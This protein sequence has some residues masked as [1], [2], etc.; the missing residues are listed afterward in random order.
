MK[1]YYEDNHCIIYHGDS[2]EILTNLAP[3]DVVL[4]D[5]P[6]GMEY[7]SNYRIGGNPF[8]KIEGDSLYD[9]GMISNFL[10]I[11][12]CG[13]FA[14]GRWDNLTGM[15]KPKSVIVWVK[16]NWGMGDLEHEFARQWE[17]CAFWAGED[18]K[19]ANGRPQDVIHHDRVNPSSMQHPTQKPVGLM[20]KLLQSMECETVLDP[21]MGS[22]STLRAAK[23]LGKKAI[24]I[25]L[26][27]RYCEVAAKRLRQE[28]FAFD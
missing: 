24:G 14:F 3:V 2:R 27:E 4:T 26:E 8:G 10:K 11:A 7:K 23:D 22:G 15:P 5:P 18:H 25:E 9:F 17:M 16:N 12:R 6:Y 28:C 13:V 19:W 1:P 21:Y 20:T